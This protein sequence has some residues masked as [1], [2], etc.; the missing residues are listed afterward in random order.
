MVEGNDFLLYRHPASTA[1][2][3]RLPTRTAQ[4]CQ[5][6]N[7][8]PRLAGTPSSR[9]RIRAMAI[10]RSENMRRIQG[11]NT[12][13]EMTVRRLLRFLGHPGYRLHRRDLPGTP[14]VA[15]I[16]RRKAIVINGCFW[17]GHDCK[18]G[19]RQPKSNQDYWLSKIGRNRERDHVN[20]GLLSDAGWETLVVWECE[21]K[22]EEAL[23]TRLRTFLA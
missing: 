6:R 3:S 7:A 15:Y 5:I 21:L 23:L 2:P 11:K 9:L 17:H 20:R 8:K 13:P 22:N 10:S 16:G 19:L 1:R 14:D 12:K 4:A 18:K